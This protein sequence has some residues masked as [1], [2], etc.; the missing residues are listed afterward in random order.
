MLCFYVEEEADS[1]SSARRPV[2]ISES[3]GEG[4]GW[5]LSRWWCP[6]GDHDDLAHGLILIIYS[7]SKRLRELLAVY[8]F[9]L[10]FQ[11]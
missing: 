11:Y 10:N 1:Y 3:W 5:V 6:G 9:V 2:L 4:L 7:S 8:L